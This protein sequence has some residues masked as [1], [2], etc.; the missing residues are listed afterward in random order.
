MIEAANRSHRAKV[1]ATREAEAAADWSEYVFLHARS[2]RV[3]ALHQIA[4]RLAGRDY[5]QLVAEVWTDTEEPHLSEKLWRDLLD[6]D[7]SGW[8][9]IGA[10]HLEQL[11]DPLPVF[12]GFTGPAE[13]GFSWTTDRAVALHFAHRFAS[14]EGAGRPMLATGQVSRS[15]AIAFLAN[16][17]ESEILILPEHV[18]AIE[19]EA[20]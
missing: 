11:P 18:E 8:G 4:G 1:E 15:N 6:G 14:V 7:R 13:A 20:L 12:R 10:G 5:W 9:S 3:G 16:R 17:E 2:H 19:V